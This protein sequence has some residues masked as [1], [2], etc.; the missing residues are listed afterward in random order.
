MGYQLK[1]KLEKNQI[2]DIQGHE[3][4]IAQELHDVFANTIKSPVLNLKE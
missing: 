1:R 4:E 3:N 2:G